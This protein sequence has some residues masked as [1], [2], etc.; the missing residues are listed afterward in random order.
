MAEQIYKIF[1]DFEW[2]EANSGCPFK[3]SADDE[4]DGYIHFSTQD[5]LAGTVAKHFSGEDSLY[6]AAYKTSTFDES[7]LR[8]EKSRGGAL[9]PHLYTPLQPSCHHEHWHLK[10]DNEGVFDLAFLSK[11]D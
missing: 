10:P 1:R 6:I 8:W 9:F 3:G 4:R 11:R 2:L 5:Q 7:S